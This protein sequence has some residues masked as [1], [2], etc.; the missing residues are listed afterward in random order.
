MRRHNLVSSVLTSSFS[1]GSTTPLLFLSPK[2]PQLKT[3]L[4]DQ[5]S[6]VGDKMSGLTRLHNTEAAKHI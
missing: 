1:S 2:I 5:I 3:I 4:D 6:K